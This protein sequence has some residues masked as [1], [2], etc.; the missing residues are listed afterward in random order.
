MLGQ[1][2]YVSKI[3]VNIYLK[4]LKISLLKINFIHNKINI[5]MVSI[6]FKRNFIFYG[7]VAKTP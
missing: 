3:L 7:K 4:L 1:I 5:N 6:F 2:P